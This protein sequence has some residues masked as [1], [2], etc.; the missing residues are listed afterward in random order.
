MGFAA[1]SIAI[2]A[3]TVVWTIRTG[4][5]MSAKGPEGIVTAAFIGACKGALGGA[6]CGLAGSLARFSTWD[7]QERDRVEIGVLHALA[8]VTGAQVGAVFGSIAG[9]IAAGIAY[10]FPRA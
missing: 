1:A 2:A 4:E 9:P 5:A 7:A 10:A 3:S 6:L 8:A